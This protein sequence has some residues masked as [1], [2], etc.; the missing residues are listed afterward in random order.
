M[1]LTSLDKD[2]VSRLMESLAIGDLTDSKKK[3]ILKYNTT[4]Y[5]KLE[6]LYQQM[7]LLRKSAETLIENAQLN[8]RLHEAQCNF[9]KV[10]GQVYH[11]YERE[12]TT[13][14]CSLIA[15]TEWST[16][17]KFFGSFLFDFDS[18]FKQISS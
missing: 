12:D 3:D 18:E 17:H 10:S 13:L 6:M 14:Y 8:K 16:Y 11:F 2:N 1:A 9:T 15:P 7:Q 4:T 5:G